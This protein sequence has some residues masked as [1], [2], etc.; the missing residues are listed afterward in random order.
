MDTSPEMA[1][2]DPPGSV[3][4]PGKMAGFA[5]PASP[6]TSVQ[7]VCDSLVGGRPRPRTLKPPA[8]RY[9]LAVSRRTPVASSMRRSDHP[10][11]PSARTCCRFSSLKT[12]TIPA[13]EHIPAP[14]STSR[15][16][17]PNGRF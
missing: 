8:L 1:G 17:R 9:A 6:H 15:P 5:D 7:V 10:S 16:L 13:Q 2:F 14:T 12:L 11:R 4:T 3:D